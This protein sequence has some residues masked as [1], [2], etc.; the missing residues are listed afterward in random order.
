MSPWTKALVIWAAI[1][2]GQKFAVDA[3]GRLEG[4]HFPVVERAEIVV[5][6][7]ISDDPNV[8]RFEGTARKLRNCEF[9]RIYWRIGK[10]GESQAPAQITILESDKVRTPGEFSFGPWI[11]RMT[12]RDLLYNSEGIVV[13]DCHPLWQTISTF[14]VPPPG[15]APVGSAP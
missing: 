9:N 11:T 8:T 3:A 10:P 14:Y 6:D 2:V 7:K 4:K 1:L 15:P 13:H 5:S 12:P